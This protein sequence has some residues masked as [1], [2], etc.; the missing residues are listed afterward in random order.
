MKKS[1]SKKTDFFHKKLRFLIY[2][3][4]NDF[5]DSDYPDSK[6]IEQMR[7]IEEIKKTKIKKW[8]NYYLTIAGFKNYVGVKN[9][10]FP[11]INTLNLKNVIPYIFNGKN[12]IVERF[13]DIIIL[14]AVNIGKSDLVKFNEIIQKSKNIRIIDISHNKFDD[15]DLIDYVKLWLTNKNVFIVARET[16]TAFS[17]GS[18]INIPEQAGKDRFRIIY[19]PKNI[20]RKK[21]SGYF[22]ID[23][24]TKI[25]KYEE[26]ISRIQRDM[27]IYG[28]YEVSDIMTALMIHKLFD[29]KY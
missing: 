18:E 2:H 23:A 12:E 17:F 13:E 7:K 22:L 27:S 3:K 28:K 29:E 11:L 5:C 20:S 16:Y 8:F 25:N 21:Q 14:K 19:F 10:F 15:I 26:Q 24:D 4:M 6:E 1:I 9:Y